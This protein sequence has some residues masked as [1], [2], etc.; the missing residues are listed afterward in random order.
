M[1]KTK[2]VI[3]NRV[4]RPE[5][6][7]RLTDQRS[8]RYLEPFLGRDRS[9]SAAARELGVSVARMSYQ[10]AR[11]VDVGLITSAGD[12]RSGERR[13]VEYRAVADTFLVALADL[14]GIDPEQALLAS[15][16]PYRRLLAR[17]LALG[18]AQSGVRADDLAVCV[19]RD[20][21]G[22]VSTTLV[23]LEGHHV[24]GRQT[25]LTTWMLLELDRTQARELHRELHQVLT[26]YRTLT[27]TQP[28]HLLRIALAPLAG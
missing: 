28:T 6:I 11:L 9:I 19:G 14:G 27:S 20:T 18:L 8:L 13:V 15:D 7:A 12:R 10:T 16:E 2:G 26:R 24:P 23:T 1:L 4:R 17:A 5:A 22:A 21:N 25:H 3:L